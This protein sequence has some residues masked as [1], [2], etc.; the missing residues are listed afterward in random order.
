MSEQEWRSLSRT[1]GEIE[2]WKKFVGL[3]GEDIP[4][5]LALK[6]VVTPRVED[7]TEA[8][9]S[10]WRRSLRPRPCLAGA[11]RWKKQNDS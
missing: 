8:F 10:T 5:I 1:D 11:R 3:E 9:F 7:Y 6:Q 4:R 2:H